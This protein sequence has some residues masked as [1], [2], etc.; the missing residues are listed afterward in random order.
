MLCHVRAPS[1]INTAPSRDLVTHALANT[2]S[3]SSWNIHDWRSTVFNGQEPL[4]E[5]RPPPIFEL[6]RPYLKLFHKPRR[7]R[8]HHP[9]KREK[10]TTT[11]TNTMGRRWTRVTRNIITS[12]LDVAGDW[13]FW[14]Y[15]VRNNPILEKYDLPVFVLAIVSACFGLWSIV[16]E[17]YKWQSDVCDL[18]KED[19][20]RSPLTWLVCR[21][22][23]AHF[24]EMIFEDIG[25]IA[26]SIMVIHELHGWTPT[27]V[28]NLVTSV[29]NVCFNTLDVIDDYIDLSEAAKT[30]E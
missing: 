27:L 9:S 26:M 7:A 16:Q 29:I 4:G 21:F 28:L 24:A 30:I 14:Q 25:Q 11:T 5:P 22:N 23:R 1:S 15:T 13:L 3:T 17:C 12:L 19:R 2:V 8:S 18:C 10:E 20:N 6:H